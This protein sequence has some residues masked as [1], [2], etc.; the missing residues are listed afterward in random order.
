M[1]ATITGETVTVMARSMAEPRQRTVTTA[2][3]MIMVIGVTLTATIITGGR[4]LL[5]V[6]DTPSGSR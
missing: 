1:V 2:I 4:T 6:I 5:Q 3:A